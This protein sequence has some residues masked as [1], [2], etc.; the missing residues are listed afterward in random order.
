MKPWIPLERRGA[1]YG[2]NCESCT[3][4]ISEPFLYG[5][6]H[7]SSE[8]QHELLIL[9]LI[10]WLESPDTTFIHETAVNASVLHVVH[11]PLGLRCVIMGARSRRTGSKSVLFPIVV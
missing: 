3:V 6:V 7:G 4:H 11:N 8:K 9:G 10:Y 2:L 5:V 1:I